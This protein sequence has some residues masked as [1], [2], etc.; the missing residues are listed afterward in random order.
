MGEAVT[1]RLR[2]DCHEPI[3]SPEFG[4]ALTNQMGVPIHY[5]VSTWEGLARR[6]DVGSHFVTVEVPQIMVY[7]GRYFLTPWVKQ[8]GQGV[9]DEVDNA[10]II[11]ITGADVTGFQPYFE[12]YTQSRCEVYAPSTWRMAKL[13][14]ADESTGSLA[15]D[16]SGR[17]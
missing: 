2:I 15:L 5:Y 10:L 3:S 6:M 1:V 8:Q 4:I 9:D 12:S 17:I 7:P 13:D 14:G 16:P 11:E